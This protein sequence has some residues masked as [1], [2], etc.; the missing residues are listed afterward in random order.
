MGTDTLR[1]ARGRSGKV[2]RSWGRCY[3][4]VGTVDHV[5]LDNVILERTQV[6]GLE[7]AQ[8]REMRGWQWA[9]RPMR[10]CALPTLGA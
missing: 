10:S 8:R 6:K 3:S 4:S 2:W 9:L 1:R 5:L 7:R